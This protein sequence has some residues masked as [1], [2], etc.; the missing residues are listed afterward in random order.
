M[1]KE[2]MILSLAAVICGCGYDEGGEEF[3]PALPLECQSDNSCKVGAE[4]A[5]SCVAGRCQRFCDSTAD[6]EVDTVCESGLCRPVVP[7]RELE[8]QQGSNLSSN[9][10]NRK[11]IQVFSHTPTNA[12][13]NLREGDVIFDTKFVAANGAAGDFTSDNF[14]FDIP[15]A[16]IETGTNFSSVTFLIISY[17]KSLV[18]IGKGAYECMKPRILN[19]DKEYVK[20]S[21]KLY[22]GIENFD[23]DK[24]NE[25]SSNAL[26]SVFDFS[27]VSFDDISSKV[28]TIC[29][30]NE[31]GL[32]MGA[33]LNY[34]SV[35]GDNTKAAQTME[36][37]NKIYQKTVKEGTGEDAKEKLVLQDDD[38]LKKLTEI[39]NELTESTAYYLA[40]YH[41]ASNDDNYIHDE[42]GNEYFMKKDLLNRDLLSA[43]AKEYKYSIQ[44]QCGSKDGEVDKGVVAKL[45]RLA[46]FSDIFTV[47]TLSPKNYGREWAEQLK[48]VIVQDYMY[49]V[50]F[51]DDTLGE[52]AFKP[53]SVCNEDYYDAVKGKNKANSNKIKYCT[54]EANDK[55]IKVT[56]GNNLEQMYAATY[57][58]LLTTPANNI[59]VACVQGLNIVKNTKVTSLL[60]GTGLLK[61]DCIG[62]SD[63]LKATLGENVKTAKGEAITTLD[64]FL[65]NMSTLNINSLI[66]PANFW[67]IGKTESHPNLQNLIVIKGKSAFDTNDL[68]V[69]Q[70]VTLTSPMLSIIGGNGF[71]VEQNVNGNNTVRS[72]V[73]NVGG[74][75]YINMLH[76]DANAC[77][78][79]ACSLS[80][81]VNKLNDSDKFSC[82]G[83]SYTLE[84]IS[85]YVVL[86]DSDP[87]G[88]RKVK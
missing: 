44:N 47:L 71:V 78:E 85:G 32:F 60:D 45:E 52:V 19:E 83:V 66:N 88:T 27:D 59:M 80:F 38:V 10:K 36:I 57:N 73:K 4:L 20:M 87:I 81:S 64:G 28:M 1:R 53:I 79:G 11:C 25:D 51:T 63:L 67:I 40:K 8:F 49:K 21:S 2:L 14:K 46:S 22:E 58:M 7:C 48:N 84:N 43:V 77:P 5:G 41:A 39:I 16:I 6:C 30:A 65:A 55:D 3:L 54:K 76:V 13:E 17:L 26:S 29:G 62:S 9:Y 34:F 42:L 31:F 68:I 61:P 82:G 23:A 86:K 12:W 15:S 56:D 50:F 37:N 33:Y 75:N 72:T 35:T 69:S 24:Y 18:E 74:D 70:K